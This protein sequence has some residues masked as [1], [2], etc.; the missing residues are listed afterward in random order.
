MG[1]KYK[2]EY[3]KIIDELASA[4]SKINRL[5]TFID[6]EQEVW[7]NLTNQQQKRHTKTISND[8][9]YALG[10]VDKIRIGD[11]IIKHNTVKN[12]IKVNINDEFIKLINLV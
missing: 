12:M 7:E 8:I 6:M 3:E 5:N 4:V 10:E 2:R 11:A 1:L 9:F